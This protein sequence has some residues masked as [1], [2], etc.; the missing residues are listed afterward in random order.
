MKL[1]R[2]Q[3][4]ASIPSFAMGDIGF[5]LLIFFV[6]LARVQDDSHVQ[7]D[8]SILP[9][10]E[11]SGMA[12]ASVAIDSGNKVFLN[13]QE[14]GVEQ[15][16][17]Q[18]GSLLGERPAGQRTVFLKVHKEAH[19]QLFEPVIEAIAEAGGDLHHILEPEADTP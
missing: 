4:T 10:V 1:A 15:L 3:F 12:L 19:A 6:I 2:R 17:G 16:S 9:D 13:G 14:M 8:P 18:L 7:W 11:A 5:L